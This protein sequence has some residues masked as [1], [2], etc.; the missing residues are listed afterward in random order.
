MGKGLRQH[1]SGVET[2]SAPFVEED[3]VYVGFKDGSKWRTP[4][5]P[6]D[7]EKFQGSL[8]KAAS[9]QAKPKKAPKAKADAKKPVPDYNLKTVR[10]KYAT[11]GSSNPI[12]KLE[13]K[14][15]EDGRWRQKLQM[16]VKEG[17]TPV[18]CMNICSTIADC[19]ENFPMDETNMD[20]KACRDC[21]VEWGEDGNH[22]F[23]KEKMD[24]REVSKIANMLETEQTL[25][26]TIAVMVL[27]NHNTFH[28]I[29]ETEMPAQ[30]GR[31]ERRRRERCRGRSRRGGG[32]GERSG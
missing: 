30:E 23:E 20:F 32:A 5:M 26:C 22:A 29:S 11:Q 16:V 9:A 10:V 3:F 13:V 25:A 18:Y 6:A 12:V 1:K 2:S 14:Q 19:F 24:W 17:I 27:Q 31:E 8:P 15:K 4:L 7:V 21:L 28:Y